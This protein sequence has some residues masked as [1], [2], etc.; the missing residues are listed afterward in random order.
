[1]SDFTKGQWD[2]IDA[3]ILLGNGEDCSGWYIV[4]SPERVIGLIRHKEDAHLI[5][6]APAMYELLKVWVNI[7]AQPTLREAQ[8]KARQLL[9]RIDGDTDVEAQESAP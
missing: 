6:A 4:G 1:M 7:Q 8:A 3:P 2:F 9:S 5:A